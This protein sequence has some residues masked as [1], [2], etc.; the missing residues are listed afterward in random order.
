MQTNFRFSVL[1]SLAIIIIAS[2]FGGDNDNDPA[3]QKSD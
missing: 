3:Q 2:C 1:F